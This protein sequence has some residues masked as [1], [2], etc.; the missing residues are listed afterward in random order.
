MVRRDHDFMGAKLALFLGARLLVLQRDDRP[1]LLWPGFWDLP[2]GGREFGE[3][4]LECAVRETREEFGLVVPQAQIR[5]G[6]AYTNSIGR[7]VWFFAGA[8]SA[9]DAQAVRFGSEGEGWD[10]FTTSEFIAHPK[11]VPQFKD[12]LIDYLAGVVSHPVRKTPR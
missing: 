1:G 5:W 6:R 4:P 7:T 10:M 11:A 2:G 8:L 9:E 12:R 3:T